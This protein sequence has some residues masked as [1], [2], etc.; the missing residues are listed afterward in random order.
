MAD[1]P[2]EFADYLI[3]EQG[4][5]RALNTALEGTAAAQKSGDNYEISVWREVKRVL[6]ERQ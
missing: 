5:E 4:Y 3:E 2:Y 1:D 6:R